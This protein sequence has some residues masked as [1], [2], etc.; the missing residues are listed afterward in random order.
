MLLLE[1]PRRER[2]RRV[3]VIHRNG[4]LQ[5]DRTAVELAGDE[6][7]RRAGDRRAIVQAWRCASTPGNAGRSDG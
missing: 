1:D 4:G 2:L 7:H 3:V 6:V 5:D